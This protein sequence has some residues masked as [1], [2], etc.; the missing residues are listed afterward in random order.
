MVNMTFLLDT[1]TLVYL[2]RG[3]KLDRARTR[4]QADHLRR[5]LR[6]AAHC[7]RAQEAGDTVGLSAITVAE[8]EYGARRSDNY[9][10]EIAAVH[11][12][13]TP[14]ATLS[15]NST[16]CAEQY[17]LVRHALEAAGETI[18]AMDLLIA[19][20]AKALGAR[21]VSNNAVHFRRVPGLVC[22][23]WAQ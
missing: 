17:G 1:D 21:L 12:V 22:E 18:G 3:L 11:K 20:H 8:L 7:R 4:H 16:T 19:A 2:V 23:N 15:F 13:F 14:F 5:A 10:A 9:E 6:I